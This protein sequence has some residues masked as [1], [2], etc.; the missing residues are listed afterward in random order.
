[1]MPQDASKIPNLGQLGAN[2]SQLGP[3]LVPNKFNLGPSLSHLGGKWGPDGVQV[4]LQEQVSTKTEKVCVVLARQA[5]CN[6]NFVLFTK[7]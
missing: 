3:K 7:V 5:F 2:L 4:G 1:M 6:L